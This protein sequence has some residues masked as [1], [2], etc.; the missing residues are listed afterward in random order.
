MNCDLNFNRACPHGMLFI[1]HAYSSAKYAFKVSVF[2]DCIFC[3]ILPVGITC[4]EQCCL[5]LWESNIPNVFCV[6]CTYSV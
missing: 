1:S 3:H 6:L 4:A 5:K 2:W